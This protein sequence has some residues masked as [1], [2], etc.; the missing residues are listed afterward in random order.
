MSGGPRTRATIRALTAGG[1]LAIYDWEANVVGRDGRPAPFDP[2]V[3]GGPAAG[4]SGRAAISRYSAV[5]RAAKPHADT[6]S[7]RGT[8]YWL[9]DDA[10][11]RVMREL[12]P[13]RADLVRSPGTRVVAVAP[14]RV[15]VRAQGPSPDRWYVLADRPALTSDDMA[16]ARR[17]Q[18]RTTEEP[19]VAM[20]FA[21][22]G[23]R[24][25]AQLTRE[26]ADRGRTAAAR[27]GATGSDAHQHF[28]V[29][30]DR[31]IVST[32]FIDARQYPAGLD[33]RAG[34]LI[35]GGLTTRAAMDLAGLISSGPLM[36]QLIER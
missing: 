4:S 26:L 18:E 34:A 19:A 22:G 25:F 5:L 1:W 10:Q 20:T 36:A 21:P 11:R 9:V 16:G 12:A 32:P 23:E 17:E 31:R 13:A 35:S 6:I 14:G 2:A 33:G 3:T 24:K 27:G 28:T 7:G 29:V 30:V 15:I 8:I